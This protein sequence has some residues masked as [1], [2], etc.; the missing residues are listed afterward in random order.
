[1]EANIYEVPIKVEVTNRVNDSTIEAYLTLQ[2][3]EG[4]V[5]DHL[6]ECFA[7][8]ESPEEQKS[9]VEEPAADKP[10]PDPSTTDAIKAFIPFEQLIEEPQEMVCSFV[11]SSNQVHLSLSVKQADLDEDT[12]EQTIS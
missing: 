3:S 8:P 2:G 7:L 12:N 1:L 5:N 6:Y 4:S 9:E 11:S 10:A